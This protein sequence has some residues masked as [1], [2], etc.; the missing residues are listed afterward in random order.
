[1]SGEFYGITFGSLTLTR[2]QKDKEVQQ[3]DNKKS[4]INSIFL[5]GCNNLT[6]Y[7]FAGDSHAWNTFQYACHNQPSKSSCVESLNHSLAE[8]KVHLKQN[9]PVFLRLT[10]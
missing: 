3:K 8:Q 5:I 7:I 1:M 10:V 4:I 6:G 9:A 2:G